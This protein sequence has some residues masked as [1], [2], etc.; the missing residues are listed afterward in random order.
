MSVDTSSW[1]ADVT[2]EDLESDPYAVYARMRAECPVGYVPSVRTWFVTRHADVVRVGEDQ[3]S[4]TAE[5]GESPA[6]VSFGTPTI[7]TVDGPVHHDLRRSFDARFRPRQV[8][9]YIEELVRP[10]AERA[11]S[12]WPRGGTV[13]LMSA[14]FEPISVLSLAHVFGLVDQD[15]DTL[16]RWFKAMN[17]GSTNFERDPH[18]QAVCDAICAEIDSVLV[19]H[20]AKLQEHP[21][22][23]TLS[24]MLHAGRPPGDPRP[25]SLVLPSLKVALIGGLQEPGHGAG[26]VLAGLIEAG[27]WADVVA[28][29]ALIPRA[30]DEGIRWVAPIGTQIRTTRADVEIGGVVVPAGAAVA[31]LLG[32]ANRDADVFDDPDRFDL[33]RD[34]QSLR[35]SQ[36]AF[37]FGKHF[38][39][40]HAFARHQIRIAFEVLVERFP[41]LAAATDRPPTFRGWE[42]RA[43]TELW[44]SL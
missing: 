39:S 26:S 31:G 20:M 33:H 9:T 10:L 44:V 11:A 18:K 40:G 19:P 14:Y 17:A 8:E 41:H 12:T 4:F 38:C 7:I 13:D 43:P 23:S 32:S 15:Q 34:P 42:F 28:D 25:I 30:I 22:D 6:E 16:R 37:G 21:D 36:S 29:P 35:R 3:E 1:L 5:N 2:V 24:H 27:Q